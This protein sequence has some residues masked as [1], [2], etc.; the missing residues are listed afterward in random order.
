[1][2]IGLNFALQHSF[3]GDENHETFFKPAHWIVALS[4]PGQGL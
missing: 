4:S 1:M 3:Y 2:K